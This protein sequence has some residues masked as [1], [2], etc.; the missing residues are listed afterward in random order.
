MN[1]S[2]LKLLKRD[3]EEVALNDLRREC[4]PSFF[5]FSSTEQVGAL[6]GTIGQERAVES[7]VFGLSIKTKGFNLYAAGPT[8]VGKFSAIKSYIEKRAKDEPVPNDWCYVNNFSDPDRPSTIF[9]PPGHSVEFAKDMDDLISSAREEISKVFESKEYEERKTRITNEFETERER[10]FG[11]IEKKASV[12]GFAVDITTAGIVTIPLVDSKPIRR[13]D[14][15]SLSDDERRVIQQEG[16]ALQSEINEILAR[17]RS[18]EKNTKQKILDLDKEITL[19]AIGH[20]LQ[21]L[22]DKYKD[23]EKVEDYLSQVQQD[24]VGN[25]DD[26][27][28][29]ERPATP[30]PGLEAFQKPVTFD[31][32]K[33]NVVVNNSEQQGAP[34]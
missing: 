15:S 22:R 17:T 30:F 10:A 21:Y 32:Y 28:V 8:G 9:F 6:D 29:S 14:Y 18:L 31:R 23:N 26:F 27:K 13:E 4:D 5:T 25:L 24:I 16:E 19:Y 34:V 2:N 1:D 33:V 3:I 7:I 12:R 11:E 20:L